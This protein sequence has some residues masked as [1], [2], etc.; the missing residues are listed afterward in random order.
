MTTTTG[1]PGVDIPAATDRL[2]YFH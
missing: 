1:Q 2:A